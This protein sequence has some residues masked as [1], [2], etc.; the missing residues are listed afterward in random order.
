MAG[1]ERPAPKRNENTMST[2][3]DWVAAKQSRDNTAYQLAKD[4][5][6]GRKFK[7]SNASAVFLL[8]DAEMKRIE[9]ELDGRS[10][11]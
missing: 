8:S 9:R 11:K 10:S 1:N 7:A 6:A 5:I 4:F 2:H 3:E